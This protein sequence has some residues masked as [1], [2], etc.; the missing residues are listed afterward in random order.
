MTGLTA[1]KRLWVSLALVRP[2]GGSTRLTPVHLAAATDGAGDVRI[3]WVRR[4]RR[5]WS[6]PSGSD[7][8]LGEEREAYRIDISSATSLRSAE[9]PQPAYVYTAAEQAADGAAG[10]LAVA[11]VQIGTWATSRPARL[12]IA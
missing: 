7:T 4:S 2:S 10:P 11:V 5:G 8:P 1:T 3:S 9:V 6:W 12:T